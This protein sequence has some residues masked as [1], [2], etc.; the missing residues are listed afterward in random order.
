MR[1]E[2]EQD[3]RHRL[4]VYGEAV[5][6]NLVEVVRVHLIGMVGRGRRLRGDARA[7][8]IP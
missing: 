8:N 2:V 1:R 6:A 7:G 3:R 5:V 4:R